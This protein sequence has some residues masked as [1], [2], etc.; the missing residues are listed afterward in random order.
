MDNRW[1]KEDQVY[2]FPF[3]YQHF[4]KG[5]R[6]LAE[7]AS[8]GKARKATVLD[9]WESMTLCRFDGR[10]ESSLRPDQE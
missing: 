6:L 1:V 8:N 2:P 4:H 5:D 7:S 3:D 10:C 9:T